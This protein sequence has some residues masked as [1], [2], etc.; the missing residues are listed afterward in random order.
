MAK[1]RISAAT[2][3]RLTAMRRKYG[4]GE[5][6]KSSRRATTKKRR[7]VSMAKRRST[8]RAGGFVSGLASPVTAGVIYGVASPFISQWLRKFNIGIQDEL[9]QI[10]AAVVL[11]NFI[12]N[13]FVTSY[14]NAAIIVNTAQLSAGLAG[15][16]MPNGTPSNSTGGGATF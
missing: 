3:A 13:K 4:L 8:K 12:K 2:R 1:R 16:I 10:L 7:V 11:K 9:M 6:Q 14:A 5:F 15:K